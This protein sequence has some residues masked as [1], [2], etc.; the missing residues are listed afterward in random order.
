MDP[1]VFERFL[2]EFP[3]LVIV[4]DLDGRVQWGNRAA[5]QLFGRSLANSVGI[6][7]ITW[8]PPVTLK[9]VLHPC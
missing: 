9:S 3:D 1:H 7:G 6:S 8:T 2:S 4:I 5:E